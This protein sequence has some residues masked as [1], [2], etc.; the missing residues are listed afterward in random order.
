MTVPKVIH[1]CWFG[2]NPLPESAKKCIESWKKYMPDYKIIQWNEDNFDVSKNRYAME[3]YENKKYAFVSDYARLKILYDNGGI[4][5]DTDV[6]LIKPIPEEF[7]VTGYLGKETEKYVATGLGFACHPGDK[8][9]KAMLDDYEDIPFIKADGGFDTLTCPIRNTESIKDGLKSNLQVLSNEYVCPEDWET[10]DINL[11]DKTFSI[12]HYDASW[13]NEHEEKLIEKRKKL[14]KRFGKKLGFFLYRFYLAFDSIKN[15]NKISNSKATITVFT[16][17]YNRADRLSEL[18]KSLSDQTDKNFEWLIVDDGSA[19]NTE[20]VV[21][22]FKGLNVKYFKVPHGG[23]HR[24]INFGLDKAKGDFFFM[25]DSDDT[26]TENAISLVKIWLDQVK[27]DDSF[28]GVAG[29][30]IQKNGKLCGKKQKEHFIDA[31]NFDRD[32]FGL[33]GDKAEVYRTELLRQHKFPEYDGE[34]FVTEEVMYQEIAALGKKLR[35]FNEPIYVCEYLEDGLTKS[36]A[37]GDKGKLEN[38]KGYSYWVKRSLKLKPLRQKY[39]VLNDYL[40]ICKEKGLKG[41]AAAKNLNMNILKF[42]FLKH[43]VSP[44]SFISMAL[45]GSEQRKAGVILS[46]IH[47]ILSFLVQIVYTP[48]LIRMMGQS[49]YGLYSLVASII[50]YLAVLDLGFGNA[51]IVYTAKFHE[52]GE[53]DKE[54]KMHGMF[55]LIYF[56]VGI[57]SFI[58][59]MVIYTFAE[60]IFKASMTMDDI[61]KMKIMLIILGINLFMTFAFSVYQSAVVAYE[62]FV[63]QKVIA[64]AHTIIQPLIMI[65]VLFLGYKSVAMTIV[66]TIINFFVLFSN[67]LFCKRKM[68]LKVKYSGFDKA[69]FLTIFGYSFW[70]FLA[71]I[72]DTINWSVD[73]TILGILSG[74]IA[75]SVY[76]V[77]T[78]FNTIFIRL[79]AAIGG[80]M[81]PKVTKMFAKEYDPKKATAEMIKV[82]RLQ[83]YVMFLAVSGF[84]LFG[85][86]FIKLW[87]GDGFSDSY[88]I[89]LLLVIPISFELIQNIGLSI[90]QAMNKYKFRSII[91]IVASV[92]N[93]LISIVLAKQYGAIGAAVGTSI[94]IMLCNIFIINIYYMKSLNIN[95]FRFWLGITFMTI[96]NMVPF[97]L[98]LIVKHYVPVDSWQIFVLLAAAY[99]LVYV[100]FEYIIV[101]NRDEKALVTNALV[102]LKLKKAKK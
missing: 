8:T 34:Y 77:A 92:F 66:L 20:S 90:M 69:I 47:I 57:I 16:A 94:S 80:V 42:W 72:V 35:W 21:K 10:G 82:G 45:S 17:T 86:E 71:T 49:E 30:K 48:F 100:I 65:P 43:I 101:M 2:K 25:V 74:T 38:F 13:R 63:F 23:K 76:T 52:R 88:Y 84:I 24:A 31:T 27:D 56:I 54:Q 40:R 78:N 26:L 32:R 83:Y 58:G 14:V 85:K 7:L 81:L 28:A 59:T 93:I 39:S 36:G 98:A 6:E 15:R 75:V 73:Q 18:Y 19:D 102:K 64:I 33:S 87:V 1:Y 12:H 4:Y 91:M 51:L 95:T 44:I 97:G 46:Y 68:N 96:K 70:V 41:T 60:D 67:Y 3:A 55:R 29:V 61:A 22:K 89:T 99:T 62:H 79:S 9:I 11:T 50:G 5:F 37:N 53:L